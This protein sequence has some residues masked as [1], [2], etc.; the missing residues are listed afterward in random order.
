M[1]SV[2]LFASILSNC[3]SI[4]LNL[5]ISIDCLQSPIFA[6][7]RQDR[8]LTGTGGHLGFIPQGHE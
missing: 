2:L 3:V 7:D 8:A 6:Q 5:D 4:I 1:T